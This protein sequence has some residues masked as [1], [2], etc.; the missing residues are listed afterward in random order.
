MRASDI[1]EA[2]AIKA[3]ERAEAALVNKES[4]IDYDKAK[5]E[6][7]YLTAQLKAVKE[8]RESQG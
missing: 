1:D 3:K 2:A 4:K 6:V 5:V 7:A 8:L